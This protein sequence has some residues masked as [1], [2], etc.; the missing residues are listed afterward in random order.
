[1]CNSSKNSC[2]SKHFTSISHGSVSLALFWVNYHFTAIIVCFK[3]VHTQ[4]KG[5]SLMC[6]SISQESY[7]ISQDCPEHLESIDSM[8]DHLSAIVKKGIQAGIPKHRIVIVWLLAYLSPP[9]PSIYLSLP[10]C[11]PLSYTLSHSTCSKLSRVS[12][13]CS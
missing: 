12:D 4:C 3:A 11:F 6:D 2:N 5:L 7:K 13:H 1:M 8:C 10:Y 9:H